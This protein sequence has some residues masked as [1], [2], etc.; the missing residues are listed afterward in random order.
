MVLHPAVDYSVYPP[1]RASRAIR[2]TT[3]L[4]CEFA[5][6]YNSLK[7]IVAGIGHAYT[8]EICFAQRPGPIVV[9]GKSQYSGSTPP[10]PTSRAAR[11]EGRV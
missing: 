11:S 7:F 10:S 2:N 4:V 5:F 1:L 3:A 8:I 9:N 6:E